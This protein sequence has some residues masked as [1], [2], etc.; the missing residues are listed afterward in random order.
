[1]EQEY[2]ESHYPEMARFAEIAQL[3]EYI[4]EGSSCQLIGLPG[5]GRATILGLMSHNKKVQTKHFGGTSLT[6]HFVTVNFSELRN[7]PLIDITKFFFLALADSLR[8][9]KMHDAHTKIAALFKASLSFND[10]LVLFQ[11]FKEAIA[12]LCLEKH[13][14]VVLLFD[15]FEEYIPTV[16]SAFFTN[17]RTLRNR[18]KYHFLVVFSLPRP[19]EM[20][21]EPAMLSDFYEFIGGHTVYLR[22]SDPVTTNF[23]ISSIEKITGKKLTKDELDMIMHLTG[24]FGKLTKLAVEALLAYGKQEKNLETFLLKQ[25]PIIATL[26]EIWFSLSPAEQT[27]LLQNKVNDNPYL[28]S[29]G[30]IRNDMLQIP[31]LEQFIR[32]EIAA[33]RGTKIIAYD[34][35]TNTIK[36]G[37][38]LLSDQLTSSEFRLLRYLLQQPDRVIEREEL[39]NAVW[40]DQKSTAGITDQAVDQLIFRL[41]RKIEEDPN[42]P[43][44]LQTVKGR[45]FKFVP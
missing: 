1:M 26:Q 5:A 38:D 4:K 29:I 20:L 13:L 34:E 22:L 11:G 7:R 27:A 35:N 30:L 12:Y 6:T 39:I 41:R 10:E 2:F 3:T 28:E 44:H 31:L 40:Q 43:L 15:R 25:K 23:R 42:N 33:Q 32:T 17:L 14:L 37:E 36:K 8:E 18:A 24:G 16:T 45:G 9:R 21:L 19:L